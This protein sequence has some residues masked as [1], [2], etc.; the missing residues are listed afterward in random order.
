[1][2]VQTNH[3]ALDRADVLQSVLAEVSTVKTD[4]AR[5]RPAGNTECPHCHGTAEPVRWS[6]GPGY[7]PWQRRFKCRNCGSEDIYERVANLVR[8]RCIDRRL[9]NARGPVGNEYPE[10]SQGYLAFPTQ[11]AQE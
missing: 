8:R 11:A 2:K 6:S 10:G 7:D 1:M 9:S 3:R 4:A 5:R